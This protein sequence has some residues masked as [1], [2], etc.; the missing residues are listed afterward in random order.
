M[1]KL[2]IMLLVVTSLSA[3]ACPQGK[4]TV[5]GDWKGWSGDTLFELTNGQVFRQREYKYHY[6]Y[7]YQPTAIFFTS[8]GRCM[9]QIGNSD[10][11]SVEQLN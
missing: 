2:L 4:M 11:V 10:P 3:I 1:K 6:E 5:H 7:A 8:G 9:A